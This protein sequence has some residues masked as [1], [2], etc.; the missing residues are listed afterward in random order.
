M[1][2]PVDEE[3]KIAS[4]PSYRTPK[5]VLRQLAEG[6]MIFE[7]SKTDS[8]DW[9]RFQIR[10]IGLSVQRRMAAEFKGDVDRIRTDAASDIGRVLDIQAAELSKV[11][12]SVFSDF[13]VV[14]LLI[15][16]LGR[17]TVREK[18]ALVQIIQAKTGASET[19]YL[20][21]MQK[22]MRLRGELI[23]LGSSS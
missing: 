20:K 8:G 22:H 1:K 14:L 15:P 4:Q 7:M 12:L 5:K 21:L 18:D 13:A 23:K 19:L 3:R 2:F 11:E 10:S 17:W 16:D 9:D 6:P